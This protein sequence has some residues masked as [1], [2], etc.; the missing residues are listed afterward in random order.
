MAVESHALRREQGDGSRS[1]IEDEK[2]GDLWE[3]KDQRAETETT[4]WP[5]D[6]DAL[7]V[8]QRRKRELHRMLRRQE[9]EN[10]GESFYEERDDRTQQNRGEWKR[11]MV[12]VYAS[13]FD[14]TPYQ[15]QRAMHLVRQDLDINGFGTYSTEQVI[16]ATINVVAREDGR[17]IE[18]EDAFKEA[19]DSEGLSM[20]YLRSLRQKIKNRI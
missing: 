4:F 12:C 19:A 13:Q 5:Q 20:R 18:D 16:L 10:Q 2:T 15:K 3:T 9:G 14:L 17:F 11:R 8:S 7:D 6:I 1:G